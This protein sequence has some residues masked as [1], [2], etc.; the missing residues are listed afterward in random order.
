[1]KLNKRQ[2]RARAKVQTSRKQKHN[3]KDMTR[4]HNH[5]TL[6]NQQLKACDE[7]AQLPDQLLADVAVRLDSGQTF[8]TEHKEK[9]IA[10]LDKVHADNTSFKQELGEIKERVVQFRKA[11]HEGEDLMFGS[12]MLCEELETLRNKHLGLYAVDT[13]SLN[14]HML[15]SYLDNN[16]EA[17]KEPTGE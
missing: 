9:C 4:K 13:S 10:L 7:F 5:I 1:M 3:D 15:D 14:E 12:I 17:K 11:N 8:P 16:A 2:Q 6:I